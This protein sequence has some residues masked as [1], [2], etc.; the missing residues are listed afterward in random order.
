MKKLLASVSWLTFFATGAAAQCVSSAGSPPDVTC[1]GTD[2]N[3]FSGDAI[4]ERTVANFVV[5]AGAEVTD[6]TGG[7]GA[8]GGFGVGVIELGP[9][10]GN[11]VTGDIIISGTVRDTGQP[12]VGIVVSGGVGGEIVVESTGVIIAGQEAIGTAGGVDG[13]VTNRGAITGD[14]RIGNVGGSNDQLINSGSIDGT[15]FMGNGNDTVTNE[16]TGIIRGDVDFENGIDVLNNSGTII[17]EIRG[18]QGFDTINNISGSI[19]GDILLGGPAANQLNN[20]AIIIGDV[21]GG[22]GTDTIFNDVSGDITGDI[23]TGSGSSNTVGNLGMLTG[24]VTLGTGDFN[25]YDNLGTHT[26]DIVVT[27]D[28]AAVSNLTGASIDGNLQVATGVT[29]FAF[30]QTLNSSFTGTTDFGDAAAI[31]DNS[32]LLDTDLMLGSGDNRLDNRSAGVIIGDISAGANDDAVVNFGDISGSTNLGDGQNTVVN[33]GLW[34]GDITTGTGNDDVSNRGNIVGNVFLGAGND[35]FT[36]EDGALATSGVDGGLGTDMLT[37]NLSTFVILG[38]ANNFETLVKTG[39]GT[40]SLVGST[41]QIFN[42]VDVS[43]GTLDVGGSLGAQTVAMA[44]GTT[45]NIDGTVD[46]GAGGHTTITGSTALNWITVDGTLLATGDLG[47]GIDVLEVSGTLDTGAGVLSLGSGD[48]VFFVYDGTAVSGTVDGGVGADTINTDIDTTASL[49]AMTGFETLNKTGTGALIVNGPGTSSFTTVNVATGSLNVAAAGTIDT[50]NSATVSSGAA[51]NVDGML[52]FTAGQDAL[53]VSGVLSGGG[54]LDL[55]ADNDTLTLRDGADLSGL[56]GSIDGNT[57]IDTVAVDNANSLILNGAGIV[58][59]ENLQKDNAGVLTLTGVQSFTGTTAIN[60]G[61]LDVDGSLGTSAV[62]LADDTVLNVDRTVNNGSGGQTTLTGSAG[63][64]SV[65][66]AGTLLATGDLGNGTDVLNVSGMLDTGTGALALGSGDDTFTIRDGATVTGFIDGNLGADSV[67]AFNSGALTLDGSTLANFDSLQKQG[68]GTLTLTGAHNYA[69]GTTVSV[70]NL[71]VQGTLGTATLTLGDNTT[72]DVAGAVDDGAA[73]QALLTGSSGTNIINVTGS[74]LASG[75]LAGGSD[76]LDVSG[77]LDTGSGALSFGQ[78]DDVF[79]IRNGASLIGSFDGAAGADLVLFDGWNGAANAS[80]FQNWETLQVQN[81]TVEFGS[82]INVG[83]GG[84]AGLIAGASGIIR[85]NA[86]LNVNGDLTTLSTGSFQ[87]LTSGS[88]LINVVGNVLNS[89]SINLQDGGANDIITVSG[90]YSGA[91]A[92]LFDVDFTNDTA[93]T[94]VVLG[95]VTSPGTTI[96]VSDVSSGTPSGNDIV[97][98][99]VQ[100]TTADGDFQLANSTVTVGNLSY[101]L[102]QVGSQW[103]L[104]LGVLVQNFLYEAYP[105]N[106]MALNGVTTH[107]QRTQDRTWLAQD[108]D[109]LGMWFRLDGGLQDLD[110][111]AS[112]SADDFNLPDADYDISTFRFEVG[113]EA[114][115]RDFT[116][117]RLAGGARVFVGNASLSTESSLPNGD[118]DTDA[119]GIGASLTWYDNSDFYVDAQIQYAAFESDLTSNG[120]SLVTDNDGTGYAASLEIGKAFELSDTWTIIPEVQ[121]VYSEV[122]F[123]SF[124]ASGGEQVSL[125]NATS[126]ELRLGATLENLGSAGDRNNDARFFINA[127]VYQQFDATTQVRSA[128]STLSNEV[129]PWR[130]EL[131]IGGTKEWMTSGDNQAAIFGEVNVGSEFGSSFSSGR[132]ISGQMGF[133][134]AF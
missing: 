34:T 18:E 118:I 38:Q 91:G 102:N 81:G 70:G 83:S 116:G 4:G 76:A 63:L 41:P 6:S 122:D 55:Q 39:S 121:Y 114:V 27:G 53:D 89:G 3:G 84:G 31:I 129:R 95:N 113:T 78:G 15:I 33:A 20:S 98:V 60:A 131:G 50:V 120:T 45:L 25:R 52:S 128:T 62:S 68:T 109:E 1:T 130:G 77:T 123:D 61:T 21:V 67:A 125:D 112:T 42:A 94:L 57:G 26:G 32:G 66:V 59:F 19:T 12:N 93:D 8:P 29:T 124:T 132:T 54:A 23:D 117:G 13:G 2:T 87:T 24:N 127:N 5:G 105:R 9:S 7:D 75:D 11:A 97:L 48:D 111:K 108:E 49:G 46:N 40:L 65:T 69:A 101:G 106:L 71:D 115:L 14:I 37:A 56:T 110:P 22:S 100:G 58:N 47:G 80:A 86:S 133:R 134:I 99:D 10:T 74:L 51:I 73:G 17:G 43:D 36:L 88:T 16:A 79:A 96:F 107:R 72:V 126:S 35:S 85:A 90:D 119:L 82:D 28:M 103:L 104:Q 92:L 30:T 64:N 44:N